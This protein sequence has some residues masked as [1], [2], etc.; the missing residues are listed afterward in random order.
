MV[1]F[2]A[3]P[4]NVE[5][6]TDQ[7]LLS[8]LIRLASDEVHDRDDILVQETTDQFERVWLDGILSEPFLDRCV[9][10]IEEFIRYNIKLSI[11]KYCQQRLFSLRIKIEIET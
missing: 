3:I 5:S 11:V 8:R 10:V 1:L 7:L 2:D 4:K 9:V 6:H